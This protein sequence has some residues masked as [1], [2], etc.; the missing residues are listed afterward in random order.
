MR[1]LYLQENNFQVRYN[2][3][4]ERGWSDSYIL[5]LDDK[6]AGY[7]AVKGKEE[8]PG[9]D[10]VFE[11]YLLP[12]CRNRAH[13]FFRE[14][15]HTSGAAFIECQS[16]DL[17]LTAMLYEFSAGVQS[18]IVLFEDHTATA[19]TRPGVQ[20]RLRKE[21]DTLF[22]HRVVPVGTHV[23]ELNEEIIATGGFLLHYNPP[24]ADLH[25]EVKEPFRKQG[26]GTLLIQELK[27]ACYQSGRV[28]A[29]RCNM[30]NKASGATLQKAGL[31]VCGFMLEGTVKTARPNTL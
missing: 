15:L 28:P 22:E 8:I 3:C 31:K 25:M 17:L 20:F 2:A 4:H 7:G 23:L 14:L 5:T 26:Y 29:A 27:K 18:Q 21:T 10:T 24:F 19:Y 16:N 11:F 1:S 9:R 13:L 30:D 6:E 12:H